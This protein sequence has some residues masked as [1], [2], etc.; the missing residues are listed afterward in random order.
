MRPR[1]GLAV[2]ATLL[3]AACA[4][5]RVAGPEGGASRTRTVAPEGP[6]P[7]VIEEYARRLPPC[8]AVQADGAW[9][10]VRAWTASATLRL[11]PGSQ[12][13][14]ESSLEGEAWRLEDADSTRLIF[15]KMPPGAVYV[16]QG[17]ADHHHAEPSCGL[18]VGGRLVI[19]GQAVIAHGADSLFTATTE[20]PAGRDLWIGAGIMSRSA[21][22]RANA[23]AA[24]TTLAVPSSAP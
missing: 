18:R 4:E 24:L 16:I 20:I 10:L 6:A 21:R 11:P 2:A 14:A 3:A 23:V 17:E 1:D 7:A 13:D 15:A 8:A 5:G 9:P 19:L 12:P 22:G